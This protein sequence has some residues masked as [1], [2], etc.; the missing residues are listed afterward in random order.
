MRIAIVGAGI[1]GLTAALRLSERHAV[2]LF[3][4]GSH[5]G[6]HTNTV[7]VE[8]EG[9][10]HAI[11]TGF[12]VYNDWT[13][14]A[15]IALLEELGVESQPTRMGFSVRC[16]R[17]GLEYSGESLRGLFAQRRNLLRPRFHR[18]IADILRFN[19]E[20][21]LVAD[22]TPG[23]DD[24]TIGDFLQRGRYG[25]EFRE[26]YLLPMGSAIWSCPLGTFE[27]FPL[28]FIAE[29]YRNHGLLNVIDRPTWRVIRG[30]S[31]TYVEQ[32][33]RRLP[34][35]MHLNCPIVRVHRWED[36]VEVTPRN[37][38]PLR[39]DQVVF[40]C[41]SDQALRMLADPTPVERELLG[42]FP[43]ER[44]T[45][46]LH[47]DVSVLPR[48]RRAWA[49]W[50]YRLPPEPSSRATV[51]YCMNILQRLESR[52]VF[53]VTLNSDDRID[54]AK[55]LGRFVY[56]HPVFTTARAAAQARQAR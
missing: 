9:E 38:E 42:A 33:R 37:G 3:E 51:T 27:Q 43:Y 1:S 46:V 18:M 15:F 17:T 4:A 36:D 10:R 24:E 8:L 16:E 7:D 32:I 45:A 29:F 53:N 2:T 55:V 31:R 25:R 34:G 22:R 40:A 11:D 28:R 49:S 41:H 50:N 20:A 5:L 21:R 30:G 56:E 44:N 48:R 14:P 26:H 54:P 23:N 19:R 52:H 13:Y 35:P 47:T 6:G 39:F 12:I